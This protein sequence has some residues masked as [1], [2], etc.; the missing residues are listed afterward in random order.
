VLVVLLLDVE[1]LVL[2]REE[3]VLILLELTPPVDPD[4]LE[5]PPPQPAMT[6]TTTSAKIQCIIQIFIFELLQPQQRSAD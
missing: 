1:L 3:L 5:P 4:G 2:D 6:L